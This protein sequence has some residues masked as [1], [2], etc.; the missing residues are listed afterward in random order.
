MSLR[1]DK[2]KH[3][4]TDSRVAK[5]IDII[6]AKAI[7]R[8]A[9]D[10]HIEPQE[11]TIVVRYRIDGMLQTALKIPLSS[12]AALSAE[13]KRLAL[14]DTENM[15][16]PQDGSFSTNEKLPATFHVATLPTINGEKIAI[17]IVPQLSEPATL[18]SLGYWGSGLETLEQTIA[19]PHGLILSASP[20]HTGTSL[21]M[22]A[23]IHL[24]NDPVLNIATI[25]DPISYKITGINQTQLNTAA[26]ITF[27]AG[28]KAALKQDPNVI[29]VS[30]MHDQAVT[31]A[32]VDAALGGHLILGGMHTLSASSTI[33]HVLHMH[34]EPFLVASALRLVA[35]QH[36]VH[37]LCEHCRVA[38]TPDETTRKQLKHLLPQTGLKSVGK[39]HEL[40]QAAIAAHLGGETTPGTSTSAITQLW[41]K[42]TT[43]CAQCNF[44][45]FKGQLGICEV[46]PVSPAI[47]K[48]IADDHS[49]KIQKQALAEGMVSLALDGLVKA[50][51]GLTTLEEVLPLIARG[52]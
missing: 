17:H 7:D 31:M 29:M 25:E 27:S 41:R 48:H 46:L 49:E 26:G 43:G 14:L 40:E 45:G 23:M 35:A 33:A 44:N 39:L 12:A 18:A 32:A 13:L 1:K 8:G 20:N 51:R 47:Q 52:A 36:F 42:S 37:K 19:S 22:L 4:E 11:R 5:T 24:L 38:Y 16:T 10:V 50:L 28:L 2:S 3:T 9:S 34:V 30:D 21:S 6:L 15:T